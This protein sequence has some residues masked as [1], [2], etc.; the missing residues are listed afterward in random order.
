[1]KFVYLGLNFI[2]LFQSPNSEL[3]SS[4]YDQNIVTI[5]ITVH[6][7]DSVLADLLI[8]LRSEI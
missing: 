7:T 1:M 3:C 4:S 2:S 6:P 8:Q 5:H